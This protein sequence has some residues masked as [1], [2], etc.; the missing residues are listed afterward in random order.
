MAQTGS[1]HV[2]PRAELRP[3]N[4]KA[5]SRG[6]CT[7][8]ARRRS[9]SIQYKAGSASETRRSRIIQ[10]KT[11]TRRIQMHARLITAQQCRKDVEIWDTGGL[12]ANNDHSGGVEGLSR[13]H[14]G[15]VPKTATKQFRTV[16]RCCQRVSRATSGGGESGRRIR[17]PHAKQLSETDFVFSPKDS[18]TRRVRL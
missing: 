3:R 14:R 10:Q 4:L 8:R 17:P 16:C 6:R 13:P 1:Q 15:R 9:R 12:T 18:R 2:T 5:F 11:S 7:A